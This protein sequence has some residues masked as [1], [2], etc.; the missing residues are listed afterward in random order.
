[1]E[2]E[3]RKKGGNERR[4]EERRLGL[5]CNPRG[6]SSLSGQEKKLRVMVCV[7]VCVWGGGW[8]GLV[9]TDVVAPSKEGKS[10]VSPREALTSL[11]L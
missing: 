6:L 5:V 11:M 3:R 9:L 10:K 1:M 7:C 4:G 8:G 2:G